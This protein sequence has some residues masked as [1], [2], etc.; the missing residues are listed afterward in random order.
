MPGLPL[1]LIL[2]GA[3]D[4]EPEG[5]L[6]CDLVLGAYAQTMP[7]VFVVAPP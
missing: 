6:L 7:G 5:N 4:R 1:V 2:R 3:Q